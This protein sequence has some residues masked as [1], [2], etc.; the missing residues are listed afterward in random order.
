MDEVFLEILPQTDVTTLE[1]EDL[2]LCFQPG[3]RSRSPNEIFMRS[4]GGYTDSRPAGWWIGRVDSIDYSDG[5][6]WALVRDDTQE[7]SPVV[8]D[9]DGKTYPIYKLLDLPSTVRT[10]VANF[11]PLQNLVQE[12]RP[13][14]LED[15]FFNRS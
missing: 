15:E 3:S 2:V 9:Y 13:D 7:E 4:R 12:Y 14:N 1:P 5:E 10:L 11:P 6:P 8:W